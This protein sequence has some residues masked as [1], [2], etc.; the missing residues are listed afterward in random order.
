MLI[1]VGISFLAQSIHLDQ[2]TTIGEKLAGLDGKNV[3]EQNLQ[4]RAE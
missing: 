2:V 3:I 4:G 1:K